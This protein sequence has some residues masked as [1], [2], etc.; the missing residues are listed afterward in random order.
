[1]LIAFTIG[2]II[3]CLVTNWLWYK[4]GYNNCQRDWLRQH[5]K[6]FD[7]CKIHYD[8]LPFMKDV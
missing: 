5:K 8:D 7:H 6:S 2:W 1:M 3:V 4:Q